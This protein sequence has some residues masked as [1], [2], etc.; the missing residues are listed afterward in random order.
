MSEGLKRTKGGETLSIKRKAGRLLFIGLPGT[1]LDRPTRKMLGEVQPGGVVLFGRNV[2]SGEQVSHLNIQIRDAVDHPVLIAVDQEGG[3]V[4]RFRHIS[5][6]RP[7]EPMPSAKA[8]RDAG[9]SDLARRF[10][11]LTARFLR[12][13]GFNMNFAPV[14]D[15]SGDNLENGLRG[16]TFGRHPSDV[17][18]LA[19]AYL[20]GLQGG[21][22]VE[23]VPSV[24]R[25]IGC[26]KH[27]PG[28]GGSSVDSHRRLPIVKHSWEEI[29]ERDLVPFMDLMFHTPGERLHSVMV[30]HAAFPEVSEFLQAWFR[31]TQELPSPES[32][33]QLP[34]TISGNV[35]MRLLRQALKFDGL[36]IT[37]D[38][39]MGAVVQT[40]SVAEA[41]LR[42]IQAG[43]DMILICER[44]ANFVAARDS[45]VEAVEKGDLHVEALDQASERMN[46]LIELAGEYEP[47]DQAEFETVSTEMR[48]LKRALKAA[49]NNEEYAPPYGTAEGSER[50][51]SNF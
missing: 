33:H 23:G 18:R 32:F 10:G 22:T 17:S 26:G 4:D 7:C 9:Q 41:S 49:E 51:S 15:L 37:D 35:V 19:G 27:F 44:E 21:R 6:P 12:L 43:S 28:L 34:A 8:V 20:E 45:I 13:L 31:R 3:L 29:F 36:V 39:E 16:R 11:E 30:S 50:H 1:R 14:L 47:F 38:M 40:L 25:I 5:K 46:R 48:E 24:G 2:E 42:A